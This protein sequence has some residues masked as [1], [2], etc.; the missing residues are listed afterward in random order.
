MKNL[1]TL[2][3]LSA[4]LA[5]VTSAHATS[6]A[7][8]PMTAGD[9]KNETAAPASVDMTEGEIRKVDLENK[10]ITIKHG[11][12]K[13]LDMPGMSMVFQVK[14]PAMLDKVKTGDKVRF[15]AEKANGAI[16]VTDMQLVK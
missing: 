15:K 11:E 10:K 5:G 13:N 16:V 6:H 7:V 3:I 12:I 1:K 4:M 8:S 14:D 2:L 9:A